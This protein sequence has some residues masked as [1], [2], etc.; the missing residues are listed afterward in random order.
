MNIKKIQGTIIA[1]TDLSDTAKEI[2]IRLSEPLAC[3][4]GSFVNI[5]MIIDGQKV[6]RA[7]SITSIDTTQGTIAI[8][9]RHT[10]HGVM[11]PRFWDRD[12]IGTTVEIMGPLGLNTVDKM[13]RPK[14][15]LFAFGIGAGVVKSIAT[16]LSQQKNMSA[17]TI[18]TG[19]RH[20]DD[21]IYKEYFDQLSHTLPFVS[22]T[23]ISSKVDEDSPY[24]KGYIQDH[25]DHLD[26]DHSDIYVC[27]QEIA[28]NEL[29]AEIKKKNP[30][31]CD[32]FIEGFH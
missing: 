24:K 15:F 5:F 16:H 22:T 27:G 12:I 28:C 21:I 14:A 10:L 9:V 32:F 1:T 7:Y 26:F 11:S 18:M 17:I 3:I 6:R 30:I 23:Y 8:S 13:I 31:D 4:A 2:T 20:K 29:V 25:I 19:N